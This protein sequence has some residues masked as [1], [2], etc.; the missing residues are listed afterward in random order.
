MR[1]IL[2]SLTKSITIFDN[3][4]GFFHVSVTIPKSYG[5]FFVVIL[6]KEEKIFY[7]VRVLFL[8]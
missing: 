7:H 6:N 3:Y 2:K 1:M 5:S 8:F 4:G